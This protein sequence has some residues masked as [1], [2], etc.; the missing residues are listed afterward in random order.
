MDKEQ[1]NKLNILDQI[2]YVNKSISKY[3]S[4]TAVSKAIGYK[5]ESTLRKRFRSKGYHLNTEKTAYILI[6]KCETLI[7]NKSN[8]KVNDNIS[9][10]K[11]KNDKNISKNKSE[12]IVTNNNSNNKSETLIIN[13][14]L[15]E[16]LN[17][18]DDILKIVQAYKSSKYIACDKIEKITIDTEKFKGQ[19]AI[20]RGMKTYPSICIEFKK[21]CNEHNE[22]RMQDLIA[23]A[24]LEYINNHN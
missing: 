22:Y 15:Q 5:D 10:T 12:T 20:T 16:L 2:E 8:I 24:F 11:V 23:M 6:N 18:K 17:V 7:N 13:K 14:D 19:K 1:F 9:E 3:G 4:S 21:F